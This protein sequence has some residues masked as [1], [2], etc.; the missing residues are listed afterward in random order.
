M[1][2]SSLIALIVSVAGSGIEYPETPRVD[3]V[4][5]LHGT[6]VADPYR[7]LE[8]DVR[9]DRAVSDWVDAQ[10]VVT[11]GYLSSIPQRD[12]IRNRLGELWNY[13]KI[14]TPYRVGDRIYFSANSG[15][16]NQDVLYSRRSLDDEAVEVVLDPNT[17]SE[18]GT[19]A[20]GGTSF[21]PDGRYLAYAVADAGSDWKTWRIRDLSTGVDL[22][23]RIRWSKFTTPAW[24]PDGS[25]FYYGR[26]DAPDGDAYVGRNEFMKLY[27]HVPGTPQSRDTLVLEDTQNPR[28][29]W[30]PSVTEDGRWLVVTVWRGS[31]PPN[32]V[33]ALD[34]TRPDAGFVD[35]VPEWTDEYDYVGSSGDR[36]FFMTDNEAPRKRLVSVDLGDPS[37]PVWNEVIP[38]QEATLKSVQHVGGEL[39]ANMMQD[40][41][42]RLVR[43]SEDG[44]RTGS[45]ELPGLGTASASGGRRGHRDTFYSFSSFTT[46]PTVYRFDLDR[47]TSTRIDGSR[48]DVD[49]SEYTVE[50]VFYASKDGTRVPMFLVRRVDMPRDGNNPTLLYGYGGF[51][52]SLTPYF[53]PV[54]LAWLEMGGLLA[55]PN[56]RGGGEYGRAWHQAGTKTRKQNVFDDFIAAAEWLVDTGWTR[57][58][59]LAIQGGSNGGLLVGAC[60]TQRPDLFGASLPA[61]GVLDML[62]FHLFTIGAAWQGDSGDVE[63]EDEFRA[64]LAYS[65]YHNLQPGTAYPAT[66]VTT[67]DTD[68]RVV[69]G[70]SFKYAAALQHAHAGEAPVLIRISRRAGHGAGKPTTMRIDETADIFA[71][72]FNELD[73]TPVVP[74]ASE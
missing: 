29:S 63:R 56:L 52:I 74:P 44:D 5:V 69:P 32:I 68:D 37:Q 47:G 17:W 65:P 51:D 45:I 12:A 20:L 2:N 13:E 40:A 25:A 42:T 59:C 26:Y 6:T 38:E 55:I 67:G 70:H 30:S 50:Q 39:I 9:A 36:L 8:E 21:S 46:P 54:R 28:W 4:D 35:V 49:L 27:R 73:C 66:M 48:I 34:L 23:D 58:A 60:M 33:K 3:H 19:V 22:P 10:N 53:S 43:W 15:L 64:L 7:W 11:N 24:M 61:V 31:G 1:M 16:Q 71:F 62:R 41:T 72:L 57:P 14:R 18:D